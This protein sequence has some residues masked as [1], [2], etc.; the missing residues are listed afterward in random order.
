MNEAEL[1]RNKVLTEFAVRDLNKDPTLPYE[2]NA[3]DV[4]TN[5]GMPVSCGCSGG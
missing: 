2:D 4:V 3:F 1:M 5:A